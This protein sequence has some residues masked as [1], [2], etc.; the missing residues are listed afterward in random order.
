[1]AERRAAVIGGGGGG[2]RNDRDD[3][4]RLPRA[5]ALRRAVAHDMIFARTRA[6]A[7]PPETRVEKKT[8][9]R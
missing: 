9:E 5:T 3:D 6:R 7:A 1:M 2:D 4:G 8:E